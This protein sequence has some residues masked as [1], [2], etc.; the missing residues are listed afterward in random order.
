MAWDLCGFPQDGIVF[1]IT[2]ILYHHCAKKCRRGGFWAGE[3]NICT[4]V[5]E[6]S[7][8]RYVVV[9]LPMIPGIILALGVVRASS[10]L[11]EMERRILL[12]SATFSFTLTLILLI[13]QSLLGLVD[14]PQLG[15]ASIAAIMCFFLLIGKFWGNWRYR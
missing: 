12:E 6:T 2:V 10:R 14:I 13:S 3:S 9:M 5:N 8:W 1:C 15:D 4:L 7:L 11:D